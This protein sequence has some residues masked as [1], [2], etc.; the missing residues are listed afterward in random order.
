VTSEPS[1]APRGPGGDDGAGT[2]PVAAA[3]A[4]TVADVRHLA[5]LARLEVTDAECERY[6]GQLSVVLDAVAVVSG[7]VAGRDIVPTTHAVPVV[8]V[9]R[10][11][12][13]RPGLTREGALAMAP[14]AQDGRFRVPQILGEEQ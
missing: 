6:V 4:L 11:D 7:V 13:V 10:E 8:N 14:A 1:T 3:P 5:R 2:A 12:V 9:D